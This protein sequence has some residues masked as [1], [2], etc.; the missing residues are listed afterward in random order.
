MPS[1]TL[2]SSISHTISAMTTSPM[3]ATTTLRSRSSIRSYLKRRPPRLWP[4]N[5]LPPNHPPL[6]RLAQGPTRRLLSQSTIRSPSPSHPTSRTRSRR[7]RASS[8]TP[9]LLSTRPRNPLPQPRRRPSQTRRREA[10]RQNRRTQPLT[11]MP[12]L[13]PP[14]RNELL[15][16]RS[17][18]PRISPLP[19]L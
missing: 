10:E 2:A 4:T 16:R 6:S 8:A 12:A 17:L 7:H 3:T 1:T 15:D 5:R 9:L 11:S 13:P 19:E 18:R 14:G